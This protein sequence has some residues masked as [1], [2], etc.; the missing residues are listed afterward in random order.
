M[1]SIRILAAGVLAATTPCAM[2]AYALQPV[3]VIATGSHADAV[4]VGDINGDG[5]D[6]VVLT[7]GFY[8][9]DAN[10]HSVFAFLQ[11]PDGSL[12]APL[13]LRY[14]SAARTGMAMADLDR[15]GRMEVVVGHGAG[16]AV[17]DWTPAASRRSPLRLRQFPSDGLPADDVAILDVDRD[18]A[19][20]VFAQSW[21]SGATI[22]FGDRRGGFTHRVHVPTPVHGYNDLKAADLDNDGHDDI[23]MLSGQGVTFAYVYYNDGT[24]DLSEPVAVSPGPQGFEIIGALATGDFNTDG[25]DDLVVQLTGKHHAL[26]LQ[27]DAGGLRAPVMLSNG[28]N[29]NAMRGSDLDLDGRTDL[30]VLY[31]PGPV[32]IFIQG[33]DGLQHQDYFGGPY[34]TWFNTQGM[35]TGDVNGD[36]C[37]DVVVANYNVGLVI[38][39]GSGCHPVPDLVPDIRLG[40]SRVSLRLDNRGTAAALSPELHIKLGVT[41]GSL[42]LGVPPEGCSIVETAPG[43]ADLACTR[44]TLAAGSSETI[45][46]PIAVAG[47][48]S[49]T[50]LRAAAGTVTG[51][52]ELKTG[53]NVASAALRMPERRGGR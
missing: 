40:A 39:P 7:T 32:G 28:W 27:D 29:A 9:D 41:A 2:A 8:F 48:S 46:I 34:A 45:H 25:R 6:D 49:R 43:A 26:Y 18:G 51:S 38:H 5:L 13:K 36:S 31:G 53:N 42:A 4:A 37:P 21:S 23:V 22:F 24:A 47:R 35:A 15:D 17:L 10:D 3:T 50:I 44:P 19:L 20:D 16:I 12:D 33:D 52:V 14:G 1:R 30:A 11:K